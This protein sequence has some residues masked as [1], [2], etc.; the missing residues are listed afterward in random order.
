MLFSNEQLAGIVRAVLAAAGGA[1]LLSADVL[2]AV[3][4][5]LVT[6]GVAVWSVLAKTKK[7][8]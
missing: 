1:T 5:A 8:N 7:T 2:T 6:L 4:G 3:A